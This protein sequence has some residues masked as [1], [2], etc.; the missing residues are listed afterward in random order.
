MA[1][2]GAVL[3]LAMV[4]GIT[5]C[6]V[7]GGPDPRDAAREQAEIFLNAWAAGKL[8]QAAAATDAPDKAKTV[9]AE[10]AER[11]STE[12]VKAT[13]GSVEGCRGE[14][15][16][17]QNFKVTMTLKAAGEWAYDSSLTLKRKN[18]DEDDSWVVQWAPSIVHPRLTDETRLGRRRELPPRASILDRTG[19]P[20]TEDRPVVAV[21]V[22][23]G[24]MTDPPAVFAALQSVG[25]VD[26]TGLADRVAK[27]KPD[28]F[29]DAV[30]LRQEAYLEAADRLDLPGIVFRDGK[31]SLAPTSEF[32]RGV[33]GTVGPAT[34]ELLAEAGP[35]A[36]P[37][38]LVGVSG[39]QRA[40]QKQLAGTVGFRVVLV[41][42]ASGDEVGEPLFVEEPKPGKPLQT[43]LD[44][45][46]QTAADQAIQGA[47]TTTALV[48]VDV[49]T[50][51]VLAAANAP[52][53]GDNRAFSGQ[54]P[55]GSTF[56]IVST[57]ALLRAGVPPDAP[58]DCPG[59]RAVEGKRFR[60][61]EFSSY[62]SG[63]L[64]VAFARSC[65][66][67]FV[68]L[69]DRIDPAALPQMAREFG[70]GADWAMQVPAFAGS[71]PEPV[72]DVEEAAAMIGQGKVLMSPLA[73]A[74]VA[75]AVASGQPRTPSVVP[76]S[77]GPPIAAL[78][79]EIVDLLRRMMRETV[80]SGTAEGLEG[81]D[82]VHA[83]TGTAEYGMEEPPRTHAWLVGYRGD[84][85][86]AVI[87]EDGGSGAENA[88]PV[89]ER[90][91]SN[92]PS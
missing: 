2:R 63:D 47:A 17:V 15:P 86:F 80:V 74:E 18:A 60:N 37:V 52:T 23:P 19:K 42:R 70:I 50:G 78:P 38:D 39:L 26:P 21:G 46:V 64:T 11:L 29:V 32:A 81:F 72:D 90:F 1:R 12:T 88:V 31:R 34:A 4:L 75:A 22:V 66:T 27:A 10:T 5:G 35:T 85:A 30:V 87:I 71:V 43:T 82:E 76:G 49:G 79:P 8:D 33:L 58:V 24:K 59:T 45:G 20:I 36:S 48:A 91:L 16:C 57:A 68:S 83:K 56:K 89:I 44:I 14:D 6:S 40:Y 61:Y 3:L 25:G 13:Q 54:Y 9:L 7:F 51:G 73:M 62:G 53:A 69:I 55:P 67:A 41:D 92:L 65:N 77:G 28:E 84:I